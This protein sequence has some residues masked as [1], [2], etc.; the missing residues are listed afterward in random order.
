MQTTNR[1]IDINGW[2]EIKGNPLSKVGIFEYSGA[3]ISEKLDPNKIYRVYRPEEE[4]SSEETLKSFRLVPWT[5]E[6]ALLGKEEDGLTPAEQKGVHGVIGEDVYFEFP[7]LK[8]NIK[9]FS[10]ALAEEIENG[11]KELS[12]GYRC[13]YHIISGTYNGEPYDVIQTDIRGNH[14]ALVEE[15]RAGPDVAVL[16]RFKFTLDSKGLNMTEEIKEAVTAEP[17]LADLLSHLQSLTTLVQGIIPKASDEETVAEIPAT[18][19]M[20]EEAEIVAED[21]YATKED[22]EAMDA[23]IRKEV[24]RAYATATDKAYKELNEK[25]SLVKELSA[26]VGTFDDASMS[27]KDVVNYG[28][29]KIGLKPLAG[30]E[31]AQLAGYLAGKK[32]STVQVSGADSAAS[33]GKSQIDAFLEGDS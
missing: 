20:D 9:V 25:N 26:Y 16:D 17:T 21:E 13:R 23:K 1:E 15:G 31:R 24:E 22:K 29:N 28:L 6:H 30:H 32:E 19:M 11:K 18:A 14:L 10:E 5:D 12:I 3:Q 33:L 8:A 4:L 7:Y 2:T 27:L